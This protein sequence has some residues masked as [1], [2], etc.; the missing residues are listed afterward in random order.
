MCKQLA[1]RQSP[2]NDSLRT[3]ESLF[4]VRNC[5]EPQ[6][7]HSLPVELE[8]YLAHP[9]VHVRHSALHAPLNCSSLRCNLPCKSAVPDTLSL[10]CDQE[11]LH[12]P[13]SVQRSYAKATRSPDRMSTTVVLAAKFGS[14]EGS[15]SS[16]ASLRCLQ[17][18]ER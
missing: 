18:V 6:P 2:L 16:L 9:P 14:R 13:V 8:L 1:A 5:D 17:V 15:R 4:P 12:G 7:R 10:A 3:C 11:L